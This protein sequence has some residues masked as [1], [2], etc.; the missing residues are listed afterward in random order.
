MIHTGTKAT[1]SY[2]L[3]CHC[4]IQSIEKRLLLFHIFIG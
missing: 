3:P 1:N 2:Q 4:F